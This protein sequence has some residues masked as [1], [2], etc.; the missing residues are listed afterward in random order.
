MEYGATKE[1]G[2][3]FLDKDGKE[4]DSVVFKH[5]Q[6][7]N[8]LNDKTISEKSEIKEL[9]RQVLFKHYHLNSEDVSVTVVE[10]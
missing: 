7:F 4:L 1:R 10:M 8:S 2:L 6:Y 5:Q 9:V 3:T